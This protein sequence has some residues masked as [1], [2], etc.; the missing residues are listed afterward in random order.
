MENKN[1][2]KTEG[3]LIL[4]GGG[5]HCKS[6]IEASLSAGDEPYGILDLPE[7]RGSRILC[8]EVI[9]NDTDIPRL[10]ANPTN[11]FVVTVGSIEDSSLR[12]RLQESV[13]NAGGR[14]AVVVASSATVSRF[15]SLGAG[16]VVLHHASVNASACVGRG[17]IINTAANV[18]HD[19]T[20]GDFTHISTG[21]MVNGGAR[22]G[23]DCFIGSGAVVRNG[24][25]ICDGAVIGAG[26]VV[27]RDITREG[28]YVGIPARKIS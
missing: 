11:E 10:A 22:I 2:M 12:R 16:T 14:M 28:V 23:C 8:C 9:G 27:S 13:E 18:E 5:G 7:L 6:V 25:S 3:G 26:S 17:C 21:A 19:V 20:I 4:I 1:N 24:V 15:A